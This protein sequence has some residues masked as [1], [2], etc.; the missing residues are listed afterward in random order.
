MMNS[1]SSKGGLRQHIDGT[2]KCRASKGG[3]R[4][5]IDGTPKCRAAGK[6]KA[7]L[8]PKLAR[9]SPVASKPTRRSSLV[10]KKKA[11]RVARIPTIHQSESVSVEDCDMFDVYSRPMQLSEST[12]I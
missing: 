4:Q 2:P 11:Q 3:L 9:S 1:S 8:W 10:K 7:T 12:W 5:H 6:K